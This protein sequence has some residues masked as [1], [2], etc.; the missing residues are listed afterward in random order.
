MKSPKAPSP[1]W[2]IFLCLSSIGTYSVFFFP[3]LPF[4]LLGRRLRWAWRIAGRVF[5][6]G[7]YCLISMQIWLKISRSFQIS[8]HQYHKPTIIISN[9]RSHLDVFYYLSLVPNIR[10]LT[11]KKFFDIPFF[12]LGLKL[13]KMIPVQNNDF[14]V[15]R[16]ALNTSRSVLLEENDPVLFFPEMTRCEEGFKG[17]AKFSLNSFQIAKETKATVIPCIVLG[18]DHSWPKSSFEGHFRKPSFIKSLTPLEAEDFSSARTLQKAVR[19]Q[20]EETIHTHWDEY[21]L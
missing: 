3:Y 12:G 16:E 21:Y 11:K 1:L 17:M 8:K 4:A 10:V 19:A 13:L 6:F 5:S 18:T 14:K 7:V 20:M 15:Y 2:P 9:H